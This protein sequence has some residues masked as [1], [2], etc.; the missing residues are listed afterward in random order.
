MGA[1]LTQQRRVSDEGLRVVKLFRL[2]R[3]ES[4]LIVCF[5]DGTRRRS[6]GKLRASSRGNTKGASVVRNYWA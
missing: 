1:T 6:T 2:G 5:F 4:R 3:R